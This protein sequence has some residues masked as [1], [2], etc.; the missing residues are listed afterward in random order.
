MRVVLVGVTASLA[1]LLGTGPSVA[2]AAGGWSAPVVIGHSQADTGYSSS[3]IATSADG[4]SVAV[5][6]A[7]QDHATR[8]LAAYQAPGKSWGTPH[9]LASGIHDGRIFAGI[10]ATGRATVVW[11]TAIGSGAAHYVVHTASGWSANRSVAGTTGLDATTFTMAPSGYGVLAGSK[12]VKIRPTKPALSI[13]YVRKLTP[14]GKWGPALRVS[15]NTLPTYQ[16]KTHAGT[17]AMDVQAAI[18]DVGTV[19]AT[20]GWS[21]FQDPSG[22]Y[23][24]LQRN[25]V[26]AGG[27]VGTV[28][29]LKPSPT[30]SLGVQSVQMSP[31]GAAAIV[32][33]DDEGKTAYA[34]VKTPTGPWMS[35]TR[36]IS[37]LGI[38]DRA[39]YVVQNDS[40]AAYWTK[41]AAGSGSTTVT[42]QSASYS[43]GT[44]S[45]PTTLAAETITSSDEIRSDDVHAATSG[46]ATYLSWGTQDVTA[47]LADEPSTTAA[48]TAITTDGVST[49]TYPVGSHAVA[50]SAGGVHASALI[51]RDLT[52]AV[53]PDLTAV[54][55]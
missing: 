5:W 48:L 41:A 26:G 18:D 24:R 28:V 14:S 32:W 7:Y 17:G 45:A 30:F 23:T 12:S 43:A 54:T 46:G 3:T 1:L 42:L 15:R 21:Y 36:D 53:A 20:W 9:V 52:G 6:S 8:F 2:S 22:A 49:Q 13:A 31:S 35:T 51:A 19:I 33:T 39:T 11:T 38:G 47:F 27:K 16:G 50:I 55:R 40:L 44:W 37:S 10:S 34:L 4:A 29:N 25:N